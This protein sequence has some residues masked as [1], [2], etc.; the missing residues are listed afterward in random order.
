MRVTRMQLKSERQGGAVRRDRFSPT[1]L[2]IAFCICLLL[3]LCGGC[4]DGRSLVHD[5]R[6]EALKTRAA[7]IDLGTYHTT[8]PRDVRTNAFTELIIHI[9]GTVPPY[10]VSTI[11]AQLKADEF[12]LR[13]HTLAAVRATT[14]EELAEPNLATLRTRIEQVVNTVLADAPVNSIGFYDVRMKFE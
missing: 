7:E 10:R 2:T 1:Q 13:H 4:Y 11:R 12:R 14:R 3:C 5:A 9:F 8:L 6:S